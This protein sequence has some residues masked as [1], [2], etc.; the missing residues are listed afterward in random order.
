MKIFIAGPRAIT[1]L[2][3][4]V[5]AKLEKIINSNFVILVGDA[6]GV[7][8][9]IQKYCSQRKYNNVIV[10]TSGERIRN[11][12]GNWQTKQ[13]TVDKNLKGFDFYTVKDEQMAKDADYGLMIWNGKSKGT[14][15]N[16]INLIKYNKIVLLYL[17][18]NKSF[19]K[20][21]NI[22]DVD[23]LVKLVDNL[24]IN[25]FFIDKTKNVEQLVLEI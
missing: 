13:V 22:N 17:T 6:N 12:I 25:K 9:A 1:R 16:I 2:H 15:N 21:K 7:D 8:K 4:A 14:F 11:N 24:E 5:I 18:V 19:Y 20:L 10:Y 23:K 3:S